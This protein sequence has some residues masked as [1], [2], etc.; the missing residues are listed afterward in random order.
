MPGGG[1]LHGV[2]QQVVEDRHHGHTIGPH[3]RHL[4]AGAVEYVE[5]FAVRKALIIVTNSLHQHG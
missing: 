4:T 3:V 1:I 5:V 2:R